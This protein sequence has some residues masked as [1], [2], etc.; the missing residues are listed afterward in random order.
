MNP[1]LST[2]GKQRNLGMYINLDDLISVAE[3][4]IQSN[5][6][7]TSHCGYACKTSCSGGQTSFSWPGIRE[8]DLLKT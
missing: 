6:P 2:G 4:S 3:E 5:H 7:K 1:W 8:V